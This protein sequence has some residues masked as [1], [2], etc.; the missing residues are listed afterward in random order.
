M[1]NLNQISFHML[2]SSF[3]CYSGLH[4]RKTSL[5]RLKM[6]EEATEAEIESSTEAATATG[7]TTTLAEQALSWKNKQYKLKMEK[8]KSSNNLLGECVKERKI[9][10]V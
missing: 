3:I 2:D 4:Q 8:N 7:A 6:A 5:V 1:D 10:I 9:L